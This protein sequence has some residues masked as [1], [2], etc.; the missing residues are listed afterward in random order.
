MTNNS[1]EKSVQNCTDSSKPHSFEVIGSRL[2][3]E[4]KR[5]GLEVEN[6]ARLLNIDSEAYTSLENGIGNFSKAI[7]MDLI[8]IGYDLCYLLIN[9]RLDTF[10][11][12]SE[13]LISDKD[14]SNLA[15]KPH[16]KTLIKFMNEAEN[17]LIVAGFIAGKDYNK[18]DL[19]DVGMKLWSQDSLNNN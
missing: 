5:L 14:V 9:K 8:K 6:V 15:D 1:L 2:I 12:R 4:R 3:V 13:S 10:P 11:K 17:T 7:F 16:S 18:L 19:V